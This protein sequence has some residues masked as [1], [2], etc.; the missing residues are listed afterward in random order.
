MCEVPKS[1]VFGVTVSQSIPHLGKLPLKLAAQGWAVGVVS[2][3]GPETTVFDGTNVTVHEIEMRREPSLLRDFVSLWRWFRLL[4]AV[5]P[6]IV[7]VGTPKAGLIGILASFFAGIPARFY[8]LRGLRLETETGF[9][10]NMLSALERLCSRL[11]TEILC[12]SES[13]AKLYVSLNLGSEEKIK[14]IGSGS[15]HGVD[16]LKFQPISDPTIV[17]NRRVG[18]GLNPGVPVIG[19]VGRISKDKGL[20]DLAIAIQ[21]VAQKVARLNILLVGAQDGLGNEFLDLFPENVGATRIVQP[22]AIQDVYPLMD[23]LVLPTHREGFPNVVLEAAAS[24]IPAIT[25]DATGAVDSVLHNVSGLIV[26]RGD[27]ISLAHAIEVLIMDRNTTKFLG[28]N[29]RKR[30]ERHFDEVIVEE[31][32]SAHYHNEVTTIARGL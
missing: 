28:D 25:T 10:R 2:S 14:V 26:R 9:R 5:R 6:T 13:L 21:I 31:L 23:F 18:I 4:R 17:E 27:P 24:G 3:A 12:V 1:I 22:E 16:L 8:V 32:L 20:S 11:A 7:S 29:A 15:S 30:V 19:Y